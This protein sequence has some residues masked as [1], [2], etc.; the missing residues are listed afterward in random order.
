MKRSIIGAVIF[1][2]LCF[3]VQ[4]VSGASE[5]QFLSIPFENRTLAAM[6]F[7]P[8]EFQLGKKTVAVCSHG[9]N[10]HK[11]V[12]LPLGLELSKRGFF[13]LSLDSPTLSTDEGIHTR[14]KE[15]QTS[16]HFLE[17]KLGFVFEKYSLIGHSDGVP[18]SLQLSAELSPEKLLNTVVI[19]SFLNES[20]SKIDR[21]LVVAGAYDQ[22]FPIGEIKRDLKLFGK[23]LSTFY[24][25][26]LSDHFTEQYDPLLLGHLTD[27]IS[28]IPGEKTWWHLLGFV[29]LFSGGITA[30]FFLGSFVSEE[31]N[32][33]IRVMTAL[34]FLF[35]W[36]SGTRVFIQPLGLFFFF[37]AAAG[38]LVTERVA[39]PV[40]VFFLL[41]VL[42]G[43]LA[44]GYFLENV[45]EGLPWLP[46][47]ICWYLVAW[48]AK[49]ALFAF[50]LVHRANW[51]ILENCPLGF[52]ILASLYILMPEIRNPL[53]RKTPLEVAGPASSRSEKQKHLF[54]GLFFLL[55][56]LWGIR[57]SQGFVQEEVLISVATNYLRMLVLPTIYLGLLVT[58]KIKV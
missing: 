43:V 56:F 30:A 33:F 23:S 54:L 17:K 26:W 9:T 1:S 28:G 3:I 35:I 44:S 53:A 14:V 27:Q 49:I 37:G 5:V 20:A 10:S 2:F 50:S 22:V 47:T 21:L 11:E 15:I 16:I 52:I 40:G 29:S 31:R 25:S 13:V 46:L 41:V 12:F 19:G 18:P 32:L 39:K 7:F 34:F 6:L 57:F 24:F 8:R 55:I 42:N 48:I 38:N 51:T 45:W 36:N 58:G 4:Y